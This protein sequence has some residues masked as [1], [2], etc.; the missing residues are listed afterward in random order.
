[1]K[2][3]V[4]KEKNYKKKYR[5]EKMQDKTTRVVMKHVSFQVI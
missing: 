1:M 5:K 2:I 4:E 3:K